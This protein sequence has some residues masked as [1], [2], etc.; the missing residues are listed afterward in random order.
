MDFDDNGNPIVD[1][2][3]ING[4]PAF[5][6]LDAL[7]QQVADLQT[8]VATLSSP[9]TIAANVLTAMDTLFPQGTIL[10][11]LLDNQTL[12]FSNLSQI[13]SIGTANITANA[14]TGSGPV[15]TSLLN[16]SFVT[17]TS[18]PLCTVTPGITPYR[19]N[20]IFL[21]WLN[22]TWAAL[23]QA[24]CRFHIIGSTSAFSYTGG[25]FLVDGA[26]EG[27]FVVIGRS[28]SLATPDSSFTINVTQF[29]GSTQT[30]SSVT[31]QAWNM[32]TL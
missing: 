7:Q 6:A 3:T 26:G 16:T 28:P 24:N 4:Q 18:T 1:D 22:M 21:V 25:G 23:T 27:S 19:I 8:Q 20:N 29:S 10:R 15:Q 30:V 13:G 11:I 2:I 5:A 9:T 31:A 12:D 17:S 32:T 14:I